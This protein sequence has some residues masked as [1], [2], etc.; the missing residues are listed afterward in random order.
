MRKYF[1]P[2]LLFAL[3][4]CFLLPDASHAADVKIL[5]TVVSKY[6][7][8]AKSW[9][10]VLSRAATR[11][12]LALCVISLVFTAGFGFVRGTMGLGDFF[13]EFLRFGITMGFF[14]WLLNN[15]PAI[16]KSLIDS[17][18]MLGQ[19]ASSNYLVKLTPSDICTHG[20]G[21]IYDAVSEFGKSDY[22]TGVMVII[23]A[24][25]IAL[26][27]AVIAAQM[28]VLLCSS[29]ILIYGGVFYLGFGGGNWTT[30]IAKNYFK[31]VLAQAMQVFTFCLLLGIGQTEIL[32]LTVGLRTTKNV[33]V[34]NYWWLFG[35]TGEAPTKVV[36]SETLT[37]TGMCV[38]LVFAVILCILVSR[39]PGLVAGVINGSSISA[40][41]FGGVGGAMAS[42]RGAM[43]SATGMLTGAGMMVAGASGAKMALNSAY[44]A[45]QDHKAHGEGSFAGGAAKSGLRGAYHSASDM[46]SSLLQG[47]AQGRTTGGMISG[48]IDGKVQTRQAERKAAEAAG[49]AGTSDGSSE[50]AGVAAKSEG[51][52]SGLTGKAAGTNSVP[53]FEG[54]GSL[55]G[56]R[57]HG[58][59]GG[60]MASAATTGNADKNEGAPGDNGGQSAF[61]QY[62]GFDSG[63][64]QKIGE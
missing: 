43:G 62:G 34:A 13:A 51:D 37:I 21:L 12:F 44:K 32:N 61:N 49:D 30:E 48:N 40:M 18:T 50:S 25:M 11:L 20:F 39:V 35:V 58:G 19:T 28:V 4:L 8:A 63:F 54:S 53:S 14:F 22:A 5:D 41:S 15:G 45:M 24:L 36:Q 16:A 26:V 3:V 33:V 57:P 64:D 31:T 7:D 1:F 23:I 60:G 27:F 9:E 42:A 29:W 6:N 17:M 2:I 38:A 56:V 10:P 52:S 47:Y 55:S 46:A 59:Q